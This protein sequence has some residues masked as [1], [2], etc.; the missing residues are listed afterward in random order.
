M[1]LDETTE[2]WLDWGD[3]QQLTLHEGLPVASAMLA[4]GPLPM[5][6]GTRSTT[7]MALGA[8]IPRPW[9]D[10]FAPALDPASVQV[11][12]TFT[13]RCER[14]LLVQTLSLAPCEM[15]EHLHA[16]VVLSRLIPLEDGDSVELA[17]ELLV[18]AWRE[19]GD[20]MMELQDEW[21]HPFLEMAL[22][23]ETL[24]GGL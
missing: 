1:K 11:E 19:V 8:H 20:K 14:G 22:D 10:L 21:V 13:A 15:G 23:L 4:A 7:Y 12:S 24:H 18:E 6:I 5:Q 3:G 2:F 9:L 16:S 17:R